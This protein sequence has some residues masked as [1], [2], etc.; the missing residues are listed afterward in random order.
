MAHPVLAL[1]TAV[2]R[3]A[4]AF[5]SPNASDAPTAYRVDYV[6]GTRNATGELE[7]QAE[8]LT[9]IRGLVS[10]PKQDLIVSDTERTDRRLNIRLLLAELIEG[11][12]VRYQD[13]LYRVTTV[14]PSQLGGSRISWLCTLD[15]VE[16]EH[17]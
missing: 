5:F 8:T 3:E 6:G 16:Y 12:H 14:E 11:D 9:A 15:E 17:P 13:N 10:K 7:G 1:S 4:V 2:L